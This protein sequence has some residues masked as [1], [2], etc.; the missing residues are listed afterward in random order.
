MQLVINRQSNHSEQTSFPGNFPFRAY[1]YPC[2]VVY[3]T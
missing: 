1:H 3:A 2:K